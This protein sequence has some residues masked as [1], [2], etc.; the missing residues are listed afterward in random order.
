MHNNAIS[1]PK[2]FST[3]NYAELEY[4]VL[5]NY[6]AHYMDESERAALGVFGS[7]PFAP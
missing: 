4:R 5:I 3:R 2:C 7:A 1:T 6:N